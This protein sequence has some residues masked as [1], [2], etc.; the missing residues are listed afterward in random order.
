[1]ET[2]LFCLSHIGRAREAGALLRVGEGTETRRSWT[3][4]QTF[5]SRSKESVCAYVNVA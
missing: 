4:V 3:V 5:V 2:S 1:M